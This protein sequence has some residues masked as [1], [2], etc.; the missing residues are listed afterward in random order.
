MLE[1]SQSHPRPQKFATECQTVST[2]AA[3]SARRA[4]EAEA[5]LHPFLRRGQLR[6]AEGRRSR[7]CGESP[8]RA[9]SKS[10]RGRLSLDGQVARSFRVA[11]DRGD[12]SIENALELAEG[13]VR[14]FSR[15]AG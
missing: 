9:C 13:R 8:P 14:L 3:A 2:P 7:R 6:R 5:I 4:A 15:P 10:R 1:E 11:D 12:P